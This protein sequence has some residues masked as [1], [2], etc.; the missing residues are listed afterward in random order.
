MSHGGAQH[1]REQVPPTCPLRVLPKHCSEQP[2]SAQTPLGTAGWR[3]SHLL[4]PALQ[5]GA[6]GGAGPTQRQPVLG[7]DGCPQRAALGEL[8]AAGCSPAGLQQTGTA[9]PLQVRRRWGTMAMVQPRGLWHGETPKLPAR[10]KGPMVSAMPTVMAPSPT[11]HPATAPSP[12][13]PCPLL[14]LPLPCLSPPPSPI[15]PRSRPPSPPGHCP[16]L[17]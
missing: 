1:H 9:F 8:D 12:A 16:L 14:C 2:S 10:A 3:G 7:S 4:A 17:R 15:C 11:A 13:Y 6:A 5:G